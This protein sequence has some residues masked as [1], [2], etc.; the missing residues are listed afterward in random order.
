MNLTREQCRRLDR[1]AMDEFG[2]PGV[3]L[4]ENAGRGMA[5]L[6]LGRVTTGP[7][8]ILCGGGNNGGDGF[9]IARHLDNAGVPVRVLL[10]AEEA[11]V[12]G[13]ASVNLRILHHGGIPVE[14]MKDDKGLAPILAAAEWVVDSLY[15]TGLAD[16]VRPPMDRVI[17]AV[18]ASGKP[19]LAVDIPSGLDADKGVPMGA[20]IRATVTATVAARKAGFD[21][22]GASKWLGEVRVVGMGVPKKALAE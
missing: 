9:V 2:V 12:R 16:A 5:E 14:V 10:F 3:V 4:M 18:N 7:V 8:A 21:A 17:E 1:R 20:C 19:V 6:L 15:G 13:D 22:P 11:R